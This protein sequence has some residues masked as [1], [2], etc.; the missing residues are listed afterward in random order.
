MGN[1][2]I[3]I[4]NASIKHT[5]CKVKEKEKEEV[6]VR[7]AIYSNEKNVKE[8]GISESHKY[9]GCETQHG[10][11]RDIVEIDVLIQRLELETNTIVIESYELKKSETLSFEAEGQLIRQGLAITIASTFGLYINLLNSCIFL[12][13]MDRE[14][15]KILNYYVLNTTESE[16]KRLSPMQIR[17][18]LR[19]RK[20]QL[21]S[22]I[23]VYPN[24]ASKTFYIV[25]KIYFGD[26]IA[27]YHFSIPIEMR[28]FYLYLIEKYGRRIAGEIVRSRG[29]KDLS[30]LLVAYSRKELEELGLEYIWEVFNI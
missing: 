18:E 5:E 2:Y 3:M 14:K 26:S 11:R 13:T 20:A 29:E 12:N 17:E 1:D 8:L 28:T 23:D 27:D 22:Q 9:C 24:E 16:I 19:N 7:L 30:Y 25:Y 4:T 10:R 15:I 6:R 21:F